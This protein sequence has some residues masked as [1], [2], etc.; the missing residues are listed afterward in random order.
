M[1]DKKKEKHPAY[2]MLSWS[3]VQAGAGVEL[4]QSPMRNRELI[5]LRVKRANVERNL[6]RDWVHGEES[7]VEVWLSEAQFAEFITTPNRGDGVPC[8]LRHVKG[9]GTL[10][11]PEFTPTMEI[12]TEE[13]KDDISDLTALVDRMA[14]EV[15][16]VLDNPRSK[17]ADRVKAAGLL[18]KL[19]QE[20]TSN[21]PFVHKSFNKAMGKSVQAAKSEVEAFIQSRIHEHGL[22]SIASEIPV[23]ALGHDDENN[24]TE[25]TV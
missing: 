8:T 5:C 21:L 4:F 9:E 2:G 24:D 16:A 6:N 15:T 10:P 3:R 23:A 17:K 1:V 18:E 14:T 12:F 7:I 20:V 11:L 19:L 22:Q 13:F 25:E